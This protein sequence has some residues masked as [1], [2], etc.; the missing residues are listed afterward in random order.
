MS[1]N[2]LWK[3][4]MG[5]MI[6]TQQH[7]KD[8]APLKFKVNLYSANCVA[9]L[10]Y[11]YKDKETGKDMYTFHGFWNDMAHL[12]RCLGLRKDCGGSMH[13]AYAEDH[14]KVICIR[15]NTYYKEMIKVATAF[16]K[17]GIKVELYYKDPLTLPHYEVIN[18]KGDMV[19]WDISKKVCQNYISEREGIYRIVK[20]KGGTK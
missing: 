3:H 19:T 18:E 17:A 15:L 16:A 13:N 9:A 10:I 6:V 12:E 8:V 11:E 7:N 4:K 5:E 2:W 1:V 14:Y 20:V